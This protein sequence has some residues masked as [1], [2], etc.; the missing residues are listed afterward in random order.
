M[1]L[2]LGDDVSDIYKKLLHI[3]DEQV[4]LSVKF[5]TQKSIILDSGNTFEGDMIEYDHKIQYVDYLATEIRTF[6][7]NIDV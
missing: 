3:S 6:M 1:K 4:E 7:K 5:C 2:Y